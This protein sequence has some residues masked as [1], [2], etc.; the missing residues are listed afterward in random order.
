MLGWNFAYRAGLF[1]ENSSLLTLLAWTGFIAMGL[2]SVILILSL[3]FDVVYLVWFPFRK[4]FSPD[5]AALIHGLLARQI[6]LVLTGISLLINGIGLVQALQ[7]PRVKEMVLTFPNL[8]IDLEGLTIAHISDL[9]VGPTLRR[10]VVE[11]IVKRVMDLNA[12][13]IVLTGDLADGLADRLSPDVAP[14][15]H[16][17]APLGL[18]YVT[19]NHEYYWNAD[20]WIQKARDLGF[21]TLINGNEVLHIR[22]VSFLLAGITDNAAT[23][24]NPEQKPDFLKAA[25][26]QEPVQFRILLAHR[27]DTAFQASTAGF[28]LVLAGHTHAGQYF[29]FN[30]LMPLGQRIYKGLTHIG[31]LQVYVNPGTAFWGPPNRFLIPSEITLLRLHRS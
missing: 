13:L 21:T 17:S 22:N 26:T 6:P 3:P 25:K 4:L 1:A 31:H 11:K 10:P 18:F 27:P 2:W 30:L 29:P 24:L 7:G 15:A 23:Q 19:G 28:D 20:E 14:L 12:D 16:L 9:H 8:P 5:A